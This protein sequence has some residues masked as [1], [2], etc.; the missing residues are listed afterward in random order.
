MHCSANP[1][2]LIFH[3]GVFCISSGGKGLH[4]PWPRA[5]NVY[6]NNLAGMLQ[7]GQSCVPISRLRVRGFFSYRYWLLMHGTR[8]SSTDKYLMP[9]F[10][11]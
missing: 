7:V 2:R 5:T 9:T 3:S 1:E 11:M 10:V 8:A 4:F 6:F